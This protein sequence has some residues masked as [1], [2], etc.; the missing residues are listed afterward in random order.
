MLMTQLKL[1]KTRAAA[2]VLARFLESK[3]KQHQVLWELVGDP[4]RP[5]R[6]FA[7]R[8]E[9]TEAGVSVLAISATPFAA[10]A[11]PWEAIVKDYAPSFRL[12]QELNFKIRAAL[13]FSE[14]Q[15]GRRGKQKSLVMA[16]KDKA[17]EMS[18]KQA[19][20]QAAE[21]WLER[22]QEAGGF[23]VQDLHVLDS[24]KW[25]M[26]E[27]GGRAMIHVADIHGRIRIENPAL[28]SERQ[29][30]GMGDYKVLGLGLMLVKPAT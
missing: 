13:T 6:D 1:P 26:R 17:P 7:F 3:Y 8:A 12:G 23:S 2:P 24:G 20:D 30:R 21:S 29:P 11:A 4:S 22:R 28:F 18:W 14:H 10:V 5:R 16:L 25:D 15:P 19:F 9:E 27:K